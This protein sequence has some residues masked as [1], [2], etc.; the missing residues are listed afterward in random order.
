MLT[1][2]STA[3]DIDAIDHRGLPFRLADHEGALCTVVYFFPKAFTPGCTRETQTFRDNY[4]E[5]Q[6]AGASVVGVSTDDGETQCK[7]AESVGA[8][9]PMIGDADGAI[10]KAYDV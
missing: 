2:G 9:F 7:F 1:V 4:A 10:T 6:L 8:P 3:P 5:L